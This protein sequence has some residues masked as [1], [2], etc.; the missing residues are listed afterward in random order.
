VIERTAIGCPATTL[1]GD[2]CGRPVSDD[3]D[4][5]GYHDPSRAEARSKAASKAGKSIPLSESASLRRD[6]KK[7]LKD[8]LKG[9]A[10]PKLANAVS[11]LANSIIGTLRLDQKIRELEDLEVRLRN[12]EEKTEDRV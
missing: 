1:A 4:F 11:V 3:G 7:L 2:L 5:C 12:L 8:V 10:D 6:L 9:E